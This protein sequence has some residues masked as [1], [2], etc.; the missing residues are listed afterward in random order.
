MS[1]QLCGHYVWRSHEYVAATPEAPHEDGTQ[2]DASYVRSEEIRT[3]PGPNYKGIGPLVYNGVASSMMGASGADTPSNGAS[4][5]WTTTNNGATGIET[6]YCVPKYATKNGGMKHPPADVV[7]TV[8]DNDVIADQGEIIPCRQTSLFSSTGS[9][10][11]LVDQNCANGDAG[12]LPGYPIA[13]V[14]RVDL[15]NQV[16]GQTARALPSGVAA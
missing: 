11:W 7:V 8:L 12:G 2:A 9:N 5:S 6:Q 4:L 16:G 15:E 10:Q 14:D 13:N 3:Q 1:T